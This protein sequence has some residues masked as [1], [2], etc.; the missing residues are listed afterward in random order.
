MDANFW[1]SL[2]KT[3]LNEIASINKENHFEILDKNEK[4]VSKNLETCDLEKIKNAH[5]R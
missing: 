5:F 2:S 4:S 1:K 3:N